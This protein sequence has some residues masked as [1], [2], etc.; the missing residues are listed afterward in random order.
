MKELDAE[1]R[2]FRG[3]NDLRLLLLNDHGGSLADLVKVGIH[4]EYDSH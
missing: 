3:E 1:V 4:I 2:L